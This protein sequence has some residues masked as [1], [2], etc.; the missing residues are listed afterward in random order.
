ML[1]RQPGRSA[2]RFALVR[3]VGVDL[4]LQSFNLGGKSVLVADE[5]HSS[6]FLGG[7]N[8]NLG[9]LPGG[10]ASDQIGAQ[11][12]D[13]KSCQALHFQS[14]SPEFAQFRLDLA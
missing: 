9:G 10:V 4:S 6:G 13:L 7:P 11:L 12:L 3:P 1:R 5:G 2:G 14:L 8:L